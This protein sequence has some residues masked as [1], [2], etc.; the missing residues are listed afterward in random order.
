MKSCGV[1]DNVTNRR[2]VGNFLWGLYWTRTPIHCLVSEIFSIKVADTQTDRQTDMLT[3]N[4]GR[5]MLAAREPIT[6][7]A[8]HVANWHSVIRLHHYQPA[9]SR[10]PL[11]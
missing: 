3:D 7:T 6:Q 8:E 11:N 10:W 2:A 4:K 5:L 1:I 9:L